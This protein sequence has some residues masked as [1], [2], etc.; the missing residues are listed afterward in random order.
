MLNIHTLHFSGSMSS[1]SDPPVI[2]VALYK[3]YQ[4]TLALYTRKVGC[5]V[6]RNHC[7]VASRATKH[8]ATLPH[9]SNKLLSSQHHQKEGSSKWGFKVECFNVKNVLFCARCASP[10]I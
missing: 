4:V 6:A 5:T 2:K 1:L 10:V 3:A 8:D 9:T 7:T